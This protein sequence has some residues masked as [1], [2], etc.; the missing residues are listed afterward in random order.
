MAPKK[1]K[2]IKKMGVD[3]P[4]SSVIGKGGL[5]KRSPM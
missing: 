2:V 1:G 5:A 4:Y 3:S